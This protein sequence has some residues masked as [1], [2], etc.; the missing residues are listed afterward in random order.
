MRLFLRAIFRIQATKIQSGNLPALRICPGE[1]R[2]MS[3][4][5]LSAPQRAAK[6]LVGGLCITALLAGCAM[7]GYD[8]KA[9]S[10]VDAMKVGNSRSCLADTGTTKSG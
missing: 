10:T 8:K 3:Q 7:Q 4:Q 1:D 2:F 9:S 6:S 5:H